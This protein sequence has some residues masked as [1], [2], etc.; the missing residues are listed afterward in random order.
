MCLQHI[1][2]RWPRQFL[3]KIMTLHEMMSV[4]YSYQQTAHFLKRPIP[5]WI[6]VYLCAMYYLHIQSQHISRTYLYSY[7]I[8]IIFISDKPKLNRNFNRRVVFNRYVN[9]A[10]SMYAGKLHIVFIKLSWYLWNYLPE[11]QS[12]LWINK[13]Q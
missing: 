6:R 1:I 11:N 4:R 10:I 8:I 7:S 13:N 5:N 2:Y 12:L 3:I 9:L